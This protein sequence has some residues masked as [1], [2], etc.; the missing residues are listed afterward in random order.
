MRRRSAF[1]LI[2]LLIVVAIIGILMSLS[3]A[4]LSAAIAQAR[5]LKCGANLKNI[6]LAWMLYLENNKGLFPQYKQHVW[7]YYGGNDP[8]IYDFTGL[9]MDHRPLNPYVNLQLRGEKGA[10]VFRCPQDRPIYSTDES[11]KGVTGRYSTYEYFGNCYIL[12][13]L[14]LYLDNPLT[15]VVELD[16]FAVDNV[17]V[18][19]ASLVLTGDCQWYY[20]INGGPWDAA[21]HGPT[22]KANLLF[23]DGHVAYTQLTPGKD[24]TSTYTFSPRVIKEEN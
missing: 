12:N 10:E 7:W 22:D 2:E 23:L 8:C 24:T 16:R 14:V 3:L 6:G 4:G 19:H 1:T 9:G 20:C 13:P 11:R 15:K 17:E 18:D 5:I 21:F